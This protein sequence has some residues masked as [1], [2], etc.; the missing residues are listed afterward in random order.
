[1]VESTYTGR[2]RLTLAEWYGYRMGKEDVIKVSTSTFN[3][4]RTTAAWSLRFPTQE[5]N[6]FLMFLLRYHHVAINTH[7]HVWQAVKFSITRCTTRQTAATWASSCPLRASAVCSRLRITVVSLA[8][9]QA[10]ARFVPIPSYLRLDSRLRLVSAS[11][12]CTRSTTHSIPFQDFEQGKTHAFAA[13]SMK[14]ALNSSA[15]R[16]TARGITLEVFELEMSITW[17]SDVTT[18][19]AYVTNWCDRLFPHDGKARAGPSIINC[20][21]PD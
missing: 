9:S 1:M 10:K 15:V 17:V 18:T 12:R 16:R 13:T 7:T 19:C 20:P 11:F 6:S 21:T 2:A 5:S 4:A 3:S 8:C 14:Q